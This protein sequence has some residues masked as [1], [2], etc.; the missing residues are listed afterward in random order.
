MRSIKLCIVMMNLYE[1]LLRLF[2]LD[3]FYTRDI[4]RLEFRSGDN[5]L[6]ASLFFVPATL[7]LTAST[8]SSCRGDLA[9][10]SSQRP[11]CLPRV[12]TFIM[13]PPIVLPTS[14][15]HSR[16]RNQPVSHTRKM[17]SLFN[18]VR[19]SIYGARCLYLCM[20]FTQ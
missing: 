14:F 16:S 19:A 9:S 5:G 17:T 6:E 3:Y 18:T 10:R 2:F 12:L 20:P 7:D 11:S 8:L 15:R 1:L 4:N 13:W